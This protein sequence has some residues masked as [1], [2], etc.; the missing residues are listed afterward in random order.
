MNA[1]SASVVMPDERR[2]SLLRVGGVSIGE[3]SVIKWGCTFLGAKNI[4]IGADCF[5]GAESFFEAGSESIVI[6]DRVYIAHRANLLT[7]THEIGDHDQRAA[8]PQIKRPVRIG[9]GCWLGSGVMLL[10]GTTVGEGCVIA[11]GAVVASDCEPHGLYAGVPA[12]RRRDLPAPRPR[13]TRD[14]VS[15]DAR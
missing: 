5:I 3:R 4:T 2:M 12:Q 10:P 1:V 9:S 14:A 7:A 8:L 11:A 13:A 15:L 6:E